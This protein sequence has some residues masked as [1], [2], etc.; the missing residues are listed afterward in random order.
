M[1]TSQALVGFIGV[2]MMGGPMARRML[3]AGHALVVH[4]VDPAAIRPLIRLGARVARS[5][6]DVADRAGVVFMSLPS[7]QVVRDVALGAQGVIRGSKVRTCVDL[8]TTGTAVE[9][10]IAAALARRKVSVIDAPVSG[11]PTGARAGTLAVMVAG[12]AA[13]IE[14]V[15]TMLDVLARCSSLVTGLDRRR[16]SSS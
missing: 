16:C 4:D 3:Q 10:E 8:S 11:G 7:P 6:K 9:K 15:R 1:A 14:R 12:S 5:P 2:G 13:S